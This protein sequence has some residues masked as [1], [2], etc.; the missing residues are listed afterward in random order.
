MGQAVQNMRLFYEGEGWRG[1]SEYIGQRHFDPRLHTQ[2]FSKIMNS[3]RVC[4]Q[5]RMLAHSTGGK[6]KGKSQ[7]AVH[8]EAIQQLQG[9]MAEISS[10]RVAKGMVFAV[11]NVF[12]RLYQQ[13]I[14]VNEAHL[15]L[16]KTTA[17]E[18]AKKGVSLIFL[19]CHKS[20]IDYL[21]VNYLFYR[22][23]LS[24]P[25][26]AAG[27]NLNIP[28]VGNLLRTCGAF[29]IRRSFNDDP[30]YNTLFKEY[31]AVKTTPL[32]SSRLA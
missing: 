12:T 26:V 5:I 21:V 11:H 20:H 30:L 24:L 31:I 6:Y 16:L 22:I 18:A 23:G 7:Q 29:F 2:I 9:L 19:P 17:E 3:E 27:D 14:H 32:S 13:G 15:R 28:I 10:R 25:F 4:S 1:Y 8:K